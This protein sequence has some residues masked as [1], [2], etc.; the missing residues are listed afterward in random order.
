MGKIKIH[1]LAK[2]LN[3]VSKDLIKIAQD[4]G[5]EVKNHLSSIDEEVA[6]KIEKKKTGKEK[7]QEDKKD[8]KVTKKEKAEKNETPVII[9]REVIIS[10][11][12]L[13]KREEE[14]RKKKETRK[15]EVGFV[16]RNKSKG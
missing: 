12:E 9:R 14:L 15:K 6:I 11:E 7:Q 10:D 13:A 4:M 3:M 2:K 1:E 8:E 16:E 5:G